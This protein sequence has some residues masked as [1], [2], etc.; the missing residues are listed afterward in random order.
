MNL[1]TDG[2]GGTQ[3]KNAEGRMQ[4][5]ETGKSQNASAKDFFILHS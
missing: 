2:H 1:T 5:A 3:I 4:N